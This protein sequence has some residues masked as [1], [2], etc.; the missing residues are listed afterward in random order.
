MLRGDPGPRGS[1]TLCELSTDRRPAPGLTASWGSAAVASARTVPVCSMSHFPSKG[2]PKAHQPLWLSPLRLW[3]GA[4]LGPQAGWPRGLGGP[5]AVPEGSTDPRS[6]QGTRS[7]EPEPEPTHTLERLA[8]R[9]GVDPTRRLC[10]PRMDDRATSVHRL[11]R[12]GVRTESHCRLAPGTPPLLFQGAVCGCGCMVSNGARARTPGPC[13]H[14]LYVGPQHTPRQ[15]RGVRCE[16]ISFPVPSSGQ[17]AVL[18]L[19]LSPQEFKAFAGSVAHFPVL[20][21]KGPAQPLMRLIC[22]SRQREAD[23]E[24]GVNCCFIRVFQ[25]LPG[26][27][28]GMGEPQK[29][30]TPSNTS[31]GPALGSAVPTVGSAASMCFTKPPPTSLGLLRLQGGPRAFSSAK[32]PSS[33]SGSGSWFPHLSWIPGCF[34]CH[35]PVPR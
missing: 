20:G 8:P 18:G 22:L 29:G 17:W 6:P 14:T 4:G 31:P 5:R 3:A 9:T 11:S 34:S 19:A 15:A 28:P 26:I 7:P 33:K 30:I 13:A 25:S 21:D 23:E 32:T 2:P 24:R 27:L 35:F 16:S 10:L 12:K 1:R